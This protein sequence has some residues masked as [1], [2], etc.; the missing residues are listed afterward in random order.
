MK[1]SKL[2]L[3]LG[4]LL[5]LFVL[6]GCPSPVNN[7]GGDNDTITVTFN[8]NGKVTKTLTLASGSTLTSI[9]NQLPPEPY[10]SFN[11]FMYW[12]ESK[13]SRAKAV[14]FD[15]NT[16]ITEDK[17]L[18]AIYCP[19]LDSYAIKKLETTYIEIKLYD[20][21][22]FPLEDGSYAGLKF[23]RSS[24]GNDN[25]W[26]TLNM[27]PPISTRDEGTYRYLTYF[28]PEPLP[29]GPNFI[30]VSTA[31]YGSESDESGINAVANPRTIT[32]YDNNTI[33]EIVIIESGTTIPSDK[34]PSDPYKSY[35][36]F[37]YWSISKASLAEAV[38]FDFDTTITDDI[39]L[40]AIYTPLFY[41]NISSLSS[42]QVEIDLKSSS[43]YP[44]ED[45][46]FAGIKVLHSTDYTN[47][48]EYAVNNPP[49]AERLGYLKYTF[50]TPL[51]AGTHYIKVTNG[52]STTG[53]KR[54]TLTEPAPVSD[55]ITTTDDSYVKV[56]FTT[57]EGYDSYTVKAFYDSSEIA[58]TTI[59]SSTTSSTEYAE[60]FG[61]NNDLTYEFTVY[62]NGTDKSASITASP[63]IVQKESD[64]LVVMYMDGDNNLHEPIYMDMNEAEYGLNLIRS[65]YGTPVPE[66]ASVN[67]VALWDGTVSWQDENNAGEIVN[68][69]P[70][71][72][73]SGTY[74]YEL[75]PDQTNSTGTYTSSG[76][77]LSNKTK[78]L[79]YTANWI[80]GQNQSVSTSSSAIHGELNM[81][82]KQTLI[83]Y[84]NWVNTHYKANT[85]IILQFSDH[86]GGPRNVRY[87]QSKDGKTI[88]IGDTSGRRALCWDDSSAS[89]FL[90][91][92]DVSEALS[93]VGFG[94]TKNKISMI[95]MDVCLGSSIEDAYQ[96][97]D[98]ADYLAASPNTIPG[99]GLDYTKLMKSLRKE[100]SVADIGERIVLDYRE[101]YTHDHNYWPGYAQQAFGKNY[102]QLNDNQKEIL[103]WLGH[104]GHTTF[105]ITDLSKI[106]TVKEKIDN[107]C[108]ILLSEDGKSKDIYVTDSGYFSPVQTDNTE[109]FID[110]I[111]QHNVSFVNFW[112]GESGHYWDDSIYYM[113]S[114]SWLY[115]IAYIAER[116]KVLSTETLYNSNNESITN[117]NA[118]ADL[119]NAAEEVIDSLDTAI[120]CSWRDSELET[121]NEDF[122]L[123]L[124]GKTDFKHHY[125]LTICGSLLASNGDNLKEGTAPD[126][127]KTDLAFGKDSKWGD[128]LEYWFGTED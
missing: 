38:E 127:Y 34:K 22:V 74:L 126:F 105:T 120:T 77:V 56:S 96:F 113:G 117:E 8:N 119:Y 86:G 128:L 9:S 51:A 29:A 12:S 5:S 71:F 4:I 118:W 52:S 112:N 14:K 65:D 49:N 28:F 69:T 24:S 30:K 125:G 115:D 57:V 108:T 103:E 80:V 18:Y 41:S 31:P 93:T 70:H 53:Y 122:Y 48:E 78:N 17:T 92:K 6:A 20:T 23:E 124:D 81:G 1:K 19:K 43:V 98:Y 50:T 46:S 11:Y 107:L 111:G 90:K 61:L 39:T 60:F 94:T 68:V 7:G 87:L 88:K 106:E 13:E 109:K 102:N 45:G 33:K 100:Y 2:V 44:L 66:Y 67:V 75:G 97:K 64:W 59:S 72:G 35:N 91:T 110:Y 114:F 76:Y 73:D 79:S 15:Y 47:Y 85:G 16:P 37:L 101:Q 123:K 32:F 54:I 26:E 58:S 121:Y 27:N 40:Y 83:N 42:T 116:I 84:L 95:L 89:S 63:E 36:N 10:Q 21:K 99:Y 62:T 55:L 3:L 82:D 25:T 104:Y